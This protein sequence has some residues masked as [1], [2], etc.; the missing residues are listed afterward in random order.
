MAGIQQ[1]LLGSGGLP[2][3]DVG[4]DAYTTPGTYTWTCPDNTE[5]VSVLCIGGGAAGGGST[6]QG[7]GGS[8]GGGG[9]LAWK[10]QIAVVAGQQYTVVVGAGGTWS[11]SGQQYGNDSYFINTSTV[12]G[13]RGFHSSCNGSGSS[14]NGGNWVGD[15]GGYGGK[16]G[17]CWQGGGGGGGGYGY[18]GGFGTKSGEWHSTD[19]E[20][21]TY[22]GVHPFGGNYTGMYTPTHGYFGGGGGGRPSGGSYYWWGAGAGGGTGIL[23][24]GADGYPHGGY[25]SWNN[26]NNY[27][28][29]TSW[30]K[31]GYG[32]SGGTA[33]GNGSVYGQG[34][35]QA[36]TGGTYGG[37]GGGSGGYSGNA[38]GDGGKGAVRIIYPGD[39]RQYP[40]TRTANE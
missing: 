32:G 9:G 39:E 36:G 3:A 10:N 19:D 35:N 37:G 13:G 17:Q 28:S 31:G 4:Q 5:F 15:D 6:Q 16:G 8:G 27:A 34:G 21:E 29:G 23:G 26:Q 12:K 18:Q 1:I 2:P 22:A 20:G 11:I 25:G 24:K 33:G 14:G 30:A 7:N 38:G 40:S